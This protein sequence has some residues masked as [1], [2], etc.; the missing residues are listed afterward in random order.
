MLRQIDRFHEDFREYGFEI[1]APDVVQ[2]LSEAELTSLVPQHNGWIIGDDPA[3]EAVLAA[4]SQ[5]ALRAAVKWGVGIDNVDFAAAKRVGVRIDHT[6]GVFGAEVADLAM[7]YVTALARDS[8]FIDRSVRI[9]RWPK[10]VGISLAGKTVALV[11]FGDIGRNFAKRASAADMKLI[12]YDP[13]IETGA[14]IEAHEL[15]RWPDGL[16]ECDFIVL[17]CSLTQDNLHLIDA[18]SLGRMKPGSRLVNVS[19]GRLIDEIALARALNSGQLY[20]AALDVFE[21]EPLPKD[22]VLRRFDRCVFGSHNASNTR[23]AVIRVSRQA[24]AKLA[25]LL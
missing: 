16:D 21:D 18:S 5:G 6:P 1:T 20:S 25:A 22:S 10:P 17:A 24:I 15:R 11:G 3:T 8:Y 19:R 4:G 2:T 9:G 12:V 13:A 7:H 23:E 14:D